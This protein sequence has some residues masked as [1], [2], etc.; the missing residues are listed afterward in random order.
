MRVEPESA[1]KTYPV[2]L[3]SRGQ[4]TIP[5]TIR[6]DLDVGEGDFL[7]LIK[8]GGFVLLLT[9]QAEATEL[10]RKF[11]KLMSEAGVTLADLLE[12][13]EEERTAIWEERYGG[14]PSLR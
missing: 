7:T 8:G 9:K 3:R 1:L 5:Q 11:S 13:L 14:A 10:T 2:R 6:D 4:I 12:G